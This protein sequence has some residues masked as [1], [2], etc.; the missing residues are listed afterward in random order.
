[1]SFPTVWKLIREGRFPRPRVVA[2]GGKVCW[3]ES[4]VSAWIVSLPTRKYRGDPDGISASSTPAYQ[5]RKRA[6]MI[7][8]RRDP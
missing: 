4:E 1:M 8:V 6:R 5:K 2:Q 7:R 3:L